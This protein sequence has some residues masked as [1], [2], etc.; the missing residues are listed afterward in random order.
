LPEVDPNPVSFLHQPPRLSERELRGDHWLACRRRIRS[1]IHMHK[2]KP[3]RT[4][5]NPRAR[6]HTK[7]RRGSA[8]SP[9]FARASPCRS[10]PRSAGSRK[11]VVDLPANRLGPG[12]RKR[13]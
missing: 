12:W 6:R 2:R 5:P 1:T 10:R 3:R 8:P 4:K 9:V 13:A 7:S 11:F